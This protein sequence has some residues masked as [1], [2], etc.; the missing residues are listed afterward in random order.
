[1]F[2]FPKEDNEFQVGHQ[3]L[4]LLSTIM[5]KLINTDYTLQ[6]SVSWWLKLFT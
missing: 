2:F 3:V 5:D 1:M 6:S 4:M